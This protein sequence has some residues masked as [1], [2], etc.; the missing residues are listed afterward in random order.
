[1][2][3][4]FTPSTAKTVNI[5]GT[6]LTAIDIAKIVA[7]GPSTIQWDGRDTWI[8]SYAAT[9]LVSRFLNGEANEESEQELGAKVSTGY[10]AYG[11]GYDEN[12]ARVVN[13]ACQRIA[14]W[15]G[16]KLYTCLRKN[17]ESKFRFIDLEKLEAM[18]E[19][20]LGDAV[21]ERLTH[22]KAY[23]DVDGDWTFDSATGRAFRDNATKGILYE[24]AD[25]VNLVEL[26]TKEALVFVKRGL[27]T[28]EE[29]ANESYAINIDR[30]T[31]SDIDDV[32]QAIQESGVTPEE[33]TAY[34]SFKYNECHAVPTEDLESRWDYSK[35]CE[36]KN[37]ATHAEVVDF[38]RA[39][40]DAYGVQKRRAK[41]TAQ[42][43]ETATYLEGLKSEL[44]TVNA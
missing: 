6:N 28:F 44:E 14:H 40:N 18:L 9:T 7:F 34:F 39:F 31:Q 27:T 29:I 19:I 24:I 22:V 4:F 35:G 32:V 11:E 10:P 12:F 8:S 15:G 3:N 38:Q 41:L 26:V 16:L 25:A 42:I 21:R 17:G 2:N 5:N 30:M 36:I 43:E 37:F 33:Y 13:D 20:D 1:M 23:K